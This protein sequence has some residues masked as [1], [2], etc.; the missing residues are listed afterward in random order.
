MHI[1]FEDIWNKLFSN[2]FYFVGENENEFHVNN[3]NTTTKKT[4]D[5]VLQQQRS[6]S[7]GACINPFA[8]SREM[9][10]KILES[11]CNIGVHAIFRTFD[12]I[13]DEYTSENISTRFRPF[14]FDV[15]SIAR[16][17]RKTQFDNYSECSRTGHI[18]SGNADAYFSETKSDS[19][20][21]T[22]VAH[23]DELNHL[24]CRFHGIARVHEK[25]NNH[26]R[27]RQPLYRYYYYYLSLLN[28][29]DVSFEED[30]RRVYI[31]Q[32]LH[33]IISRLI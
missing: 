7:I 26:R 24:S 11:N 22:N 6:H 25:L 14:S 17:R 30:L 19:F 31:S 23:A 32:R 33:F 16:F 28:T 29:I 18:D 8:N 12:R 5:V 13:V 4:N 20:P 2:I 9:F 15:H 21:A 27:G 3:T 10:R 1:V